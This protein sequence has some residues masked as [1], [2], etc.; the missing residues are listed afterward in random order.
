MRVRCSNL[1]LI[2]AVELL[3]LTAAIPLARA[4]RYARMRASCVNGLK[5]QPA[6]VV[7]QVVTEQ[8]ER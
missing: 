6:Q 2:L 4:V 3:L 5:E 7:A 1:M 8:R